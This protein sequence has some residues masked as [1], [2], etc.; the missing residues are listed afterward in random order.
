MEVDDHDVH[1]G[2]VNDYDDDE[3]TFGQNP[4]KIQR[5]HMNEDDDEDDEEDEDD[6]DDGNDDRG[7]SRKAK[8]QSAVGLT[9]CLKG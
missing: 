7:D 1:M 3:E 2:G 8:V 6:E 9:S 4:N 5:K